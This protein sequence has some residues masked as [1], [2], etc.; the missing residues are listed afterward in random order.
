MPVYFGHKNHRGLSVSPA[1]QSLGIDLLRSTPNDVSAISRPLVV[2]PGYTSYVSHLSAFMKA[3]L[4]RV[5]VPLNQQGYLAQLP[6]N[7]CIQIGHPPLVIDYNGPI[8]SKH[9]DILGTI[10]FERIK[11]NKT[12]NILRFPSITLD[13]A[14]EIHRTNPNL[15]TPAPVNTVNLA[16]FESWISVLKLVSLL[17]LSHTYPAFTD[18][19]HFLGDIDTLL[20]DLTKRKA[21]SE[22]GNTPK[23]AR[24]GDAVNRNRGE[25]DEEMVDE[26][27]LLLPDES[28]ITLHKA[29]PP[30]NNVPGWG[31][32]DELP[33]AS[34]LF[35]PFVP[36]LT[37]YDTV[38]VP[39]LIETF[40]IQSLGNKPEKQLEI[41]DKIRS[42]WGIIGKTDAGNAMAHLCKVI[43]LSLRA[44]ARAFPFV[45][46]GVYQGC[47]LSGGRFWVGV[48]GQVYRPLSYIKLQEETGSYHMHSRVLDRIME[49]VDDVDFARPETMRSLRQVL[50]AA[51]LTEEDRDE[52]RKLSVSLHF[53]NDKFLAVNAQTLMR[54]LQDIISL[55]DAEDLSLPMHHSALFSRDKVFVSLSSFGYQAPSFQIDNCPKVSLSS[56]KPPQT[57]VVRQKPL[58]VATVDWKSMIESKEM[59]NNP[60]NL[61][62]AN[63]DRSIVGND[64]T[65]LWGELVKFARAVGGREQDRSGIVEEEGRE[66]DDDDLNVWD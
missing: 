21:G 66:A 23:R 17:L 62:R 15:T 53:K 26:D 32:P 6:L 27:D 12:D 54:V 9:V 50:L 31:T 3:Y 2:Q 14:K 25:G 36:E 5:N 65:A 37:S 55:G 38:T 59:R 19:D 39:R 33:N 30:R 16:A 52:V 10:G 56:V 11:M 42:A 46:D 20:E 35:F 28:T 41:L 60:R 63:R 57:L 49:L 45:I 61:S 1:L 8:P 34:G 29:K 7:Q 13:Q 51:T 64:K 40:L 47:V 58:D 43:H 22:L 44:Q 18:D 4:T 24:Q 48:N